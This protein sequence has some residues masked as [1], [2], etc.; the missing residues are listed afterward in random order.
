MHLS[1]LLLSVLLIVYISY[2]TFQDISFMRDKAYMR[3]Q[4]WV[5]VVFLLDFGVELLFAENRIRFLK[6]NFFFLI[7]SIP[8]LNIIEAQGWLVPYEQMYFMRFIPLLRGAFALAVVVGY[9]STNRISSLF[10]SY[11]AIIISAV[12]FASLIFFKV[13]YPVNQGIKNYG[14]ALWWAC[15]NV[16]TLGAPIIPVTDI[17]KAL[18]VALGGLGM[19]MFPLFTVYITNLVNE[20]NKRI[21]ANITHKSKGK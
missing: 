7:I 17:G 15:M 10:A 19:M 20:A 13:E 14:D 12:Y 3:F 4:L 16:T 5:C 18:C 2:D 1:V 6:R 21:K 11:I 9:V 8:Y